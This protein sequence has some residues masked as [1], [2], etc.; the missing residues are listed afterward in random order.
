MTKNDMRTPTAVAVFAMAEI[1]TAVEAF[2]DGATNLFDALDA[3][4]I[5]VE[6][7]RAAASGLRQAA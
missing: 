4:T 3:I 7:H 2:E 1:K 5:A 6:A